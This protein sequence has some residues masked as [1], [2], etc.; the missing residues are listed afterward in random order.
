MLIINTFI[1]WHASYIHACTHAACMQSNASIML[2]CCIHV[3]ACM[4]CLHVACMHMHA[5]NWAKC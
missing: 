3:N 2:A 1:K 4:Q 5:C